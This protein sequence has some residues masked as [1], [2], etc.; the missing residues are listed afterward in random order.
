MELTP[1]KLNVLDKGVV[2]ALELLEGAAVTEIALACGTATAGRYE[3]RRKDRT[4]KDIASQTNVHKKK[5]TQHP[6]R[7]SQAGIGGN[8]SYFQQLHTI[9]LCV[10]MYVNVNRIII[11]QDETFRQKVWHSLFTLP[12]CSIQLLFR[13][14]LQDIVSSFLSSVSFS[15]FYNPN[16]RSSKISM[17]IVATPTPNRG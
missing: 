3:A 8:L 7:T 16:Q 15:L 4:K 1:G 10:Y 12:F 2:K 5:C 17:P 9:I 13:S 6:R 11:I 14:I